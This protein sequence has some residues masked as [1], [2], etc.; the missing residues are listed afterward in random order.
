MWEEVIEKAGD[1]EAKANLQPLFYVCEIDF[2]SP[3]D[4]RLLSKKDQKNTQQEHHNEAPK[5]KAQSQT[6]S[7]THRP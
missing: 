2:R 5:K 3:Q 4:H 1:V 6:S 7:T